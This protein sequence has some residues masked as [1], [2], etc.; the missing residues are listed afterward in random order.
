VVAWAEPVEAKVEVAQVEVGVE[1]HVLPGCKEAGE[2]AAGGGEAEAEEK[3]KKGT[4][5][6]E[7]AVTGAAPRRE[8]VAI[9]LAQVVGAEEVSTQA[10]MRQAQL[11]VRIVLV[12]IAR[13]RNIF[14]CC[15]LHIGAVK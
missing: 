2:L 9:A 13:R 8:E 12:L 14:Y 4:E 7:A 15:A 6:E 3:V 1:V 11:D 10:R 5:E